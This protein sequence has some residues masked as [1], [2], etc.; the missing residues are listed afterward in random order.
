V[1]SQLQHCLKISAPQVG[2]MFW[3]KP[4]LKPFGPGHLS[5]FI[6]KID[7][8]NFSIIKGAIKFQL[9]SSKI[10]S[11]TTSITEILAASFHM[12]YT[13]FQHQIRT[14]CRVRCFNIELAEN[15]QIEANITNVEFLAHELEVVLICSVR[16]INV[17]V[18]PFNV[19]TSC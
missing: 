6:E 5:A 9:S 7:A 12:F 19:P 15:R 14:K 4:E 3:K 1:F 10:A 13:M 2:Q 17:C 8:L 16:C 18:V 11:D